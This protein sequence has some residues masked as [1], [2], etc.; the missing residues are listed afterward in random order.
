MQALASATTP[1]ISLNS[2]TEPLNSE[3]EILGIDNLI[4][5]SVPRHIFTFISPVGNDLGDINRDTGSTGIYVT[6]VNSSINL[7]V[8]SR[9]GSFKVEVPSSKFPWQRVP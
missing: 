9:G 4:M 5:I 1:Y 8:N 2:F 3:G 6:A 7:G